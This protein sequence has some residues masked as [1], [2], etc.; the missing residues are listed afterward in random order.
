MPTESL[1]TVKS[2]AEM[3]IG[4]I[5]RTFS[6]PPN[7]HPLYATVGR[8][9]AEWAELEHGLDQIIWRLSG[10]TSQLGG[11]H[12]TARDPAPGLLTASLA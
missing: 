4:V 12:R 9:A 7:D 3:P 10:T 11:V 5:V 2:D 1:A 6:K 8:V